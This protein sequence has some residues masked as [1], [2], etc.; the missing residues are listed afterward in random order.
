MKNDTNYLKKVREQYENYPYPERDPEQELERL[1]STTT[2]RLPIINHHGFGGRQDFSKDFRFLVA[3][4]GTGDTTIY[5]AEQLRNLPGA[6]LVY[7]DISQASMDICK[8]R[9][10]KR[11][12]E[13]IRFV[14]GSLLDLPDMDLGDFDYISCSGVLHH[15]ENPDEGLRALVSVLKPEGVMGL[16]VYATYGRTGVYQMQELMRRINRN[17]PN[18][19]KQVDNT[20]VMLQEIPKTNWFRFSAKSIRDWQVGDIGIY[21]LLLHSQDRSYT[22]DEVYDFVENAGLH[23]LDFSDPRYQQMYRPENLIKDKTIARELASLPVR[24]RQAIGE[25]FFGNILKHTFYCSRKPAPQADYH[26]LDLVPC[27]LDMNHNEMADAL[28]AAQKQHGTVTTSAR[29][30]LKITMQPNPENIVLF[31]ELDGQRSMNEIL[32][33]LAK[34][35]TTKR[36]SK[37]KLVKEYHRLCEILIPTQMLALR[38]RDVPLFPSHD[39]LSKQIHRILE[40]EKTD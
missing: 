36:M 5:L 16:M 21:D 1:Y 34:E 9:A 25:V 28:R 23:F 4:G 37:T 32:E 13:N 18:L 14:H 3:G 10:E 29:G 17:E 26:D 35:E 31:Q 19:Q 30:Y 2:D 12:L 8:R 22:V 15:L 27:L 24:Q 39:D 33:E 11:Q 20:K 6:E 7:L 38:H 40:Q